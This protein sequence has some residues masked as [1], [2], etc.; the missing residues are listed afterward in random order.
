M[1][2]GP[3]RRSTSVILFLA[4]ALGVS[5]GKEA[6]GNTGPTDAAGS[7]GS[8]ADAT[9]GSGGS[10]AAGTGGSA[11]GGATGSGGAISGS[12]GTTGSGG[13]SSDA[14]MDTSGTGGSVV[15]GNDIT[16]AAPT[17]G[18]GTAP[19]ATGAQTIMTM[20]TKAAGCGDTNCGPWMYPRDYVVTLPQGYVNTKA[21]PLVFDAP[22]CGG[23]GANV[24]TLNNNVND[25]VILV[26]LSP[27]PNAI[28]HPTNPGV[29]CF[30]DHEGDDSVDFVLYE[31]LWDK[32]AAQFCFDKNRVF[33][34]GTGSGAVISNGVACKYAGDATRPLRAPLPND[35]A[36]LSQPSSAPTCTSKPMAGMWIDDPNGLTNNKLAIARAMMVNKCTIGTG[37]DNT[38][39]DNFP[40]G[41]GNPD[42]TCRKIRGC[43]ELYPLVVC[44]I[45][46]TG[47]HDSVANPGFSTFISLFEK[48]PFQTP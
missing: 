15:G 35:G 31:T 42:G 40:I 39:F 17:A 5:C 16:K 44:Q 21:Y 23:N 18:C 41:G 8:S 45:A 4:L 3:R 22:T 34:A 26:G 19:G 11:T 28:G 37:V 29:G 30:D 14:A 10:T 32:L 7:G 9:A 1:I 48:A 43:P 2:A 24:Y 47:T 6:L 27:P 33:F 36:L 13:T 46:G 25:T 12:G 38:M 20:G